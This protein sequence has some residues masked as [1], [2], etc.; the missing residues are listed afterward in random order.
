M[1]PLDFSV[2][3]WMDDASCLNQDPEIWFPEH[4]YSS[5]VARRICNGV[6][7]RAG[8]REPCPVRAECLLYALQ[9]DSREGV[10][11]GLS[12]RQRRGLHAAHARTQ[13]ETA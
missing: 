13:R 3:P 10:W 2:P 8:V 12:E 6:P 11:G 7:D 1:S 5:K 4:N 9:T